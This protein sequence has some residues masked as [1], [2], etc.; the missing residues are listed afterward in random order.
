[1]ASFLRHASVL[2]LVGWI[3]GL[4]ACAKKPLVESHLPAG[5]T[6]VPYDAFLAGIFDD[7][8]EPGAV[9]PMISSSTRNR[10]L[11]AERTRTAHSVTRVRVQTVTSDQVDGAPVYHVSLVAIGEP[12]AKSALPENRAELV[13]AKLTPAFGIVKAFDAQ[14]VGRSFVGFFRWF[15]P[16]SEADEPQLHW[17]LSPDDPDLIAALREISLGAEPPSR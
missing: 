3:F 2:A 16:M 9:G 11:L 8:I 4:T 5:A 1:M 10:P 14:L 15:S 7:V 12:L 6:L 13:I 17:H